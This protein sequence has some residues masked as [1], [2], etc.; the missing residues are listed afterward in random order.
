M[1]VNISI[2]L[3]VILQYVYT[4]LSIRCDKV[5]FKKYDENC[6]KLTTIGNS[7][8]NFPESNGKELKR[9]CQ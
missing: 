6:A 1:H 8:R 2:K 3:L 9:F 5:G 7:G 4:V